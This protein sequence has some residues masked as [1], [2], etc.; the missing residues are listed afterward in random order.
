MDRQSELRGAEALLEIR[1]MP[2][3]KPPHGLFERLATT[4]LE[5]RESGRSRGGFWAG[6]GL[7]LAAAA[8][9]VAVALAAG[10]L[11]P[12]AVSSEVTP[13][14]AFSV[15]AGQARIMDVAIETE[16]ALSNASISVE[17]VG[18][19]QIEGYG[20][21]RQLSWSDDLDAGV[22][23]LSLPIVA[24]G[25]GGGQVLVKLTHPRSQKSWLIDL[26]TGV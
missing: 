10:W 14:V 26:E 7:G 12:G 24:T 5:E 13:S 3:G 6:T 16:A 25:S 2:V 8:G 17:L 21:Q 15:P 11:T 9:I 20:Q 4:A 19:I 1:E 22:N 18:D 23:R